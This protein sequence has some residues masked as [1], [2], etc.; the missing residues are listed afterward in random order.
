MLSGRDDGTANERMNER[1][2]EVRWSDIRKIS[3][4]S[5]KRYEMRLV[6]SK[7]TQKKIITR[8]DRNAWLSPLPALR[9][10]TCVCTVLPHRKI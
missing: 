1:L 3:S 6:L 2:L 9:R 7:P 8:Q 5:G 10:S 4:Q